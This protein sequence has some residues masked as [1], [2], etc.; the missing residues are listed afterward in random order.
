[1]QHYTQQY[2]EGEIE[3]PILNSSMLALLTEGK[4]PKVQFE[5]GEKYEYSNTGCALL[6]SVIEKVSGQTYPEFL[7]ETFLN[8]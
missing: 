7:Q 4:L 5:P 2:R 6:A 8:L 1:M 3:E